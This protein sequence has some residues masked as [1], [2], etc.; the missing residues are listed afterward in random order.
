[1][2]FHIKQKQ[3]DAVVKKKTFQGRAVKEEV[4][5]SESMAFLNF[6]E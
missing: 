5:E 3:D 4:F 2:T 1:M 6:V